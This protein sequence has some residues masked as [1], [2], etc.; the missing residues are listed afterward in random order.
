MSV[1][2]DVLNA[3]S[4]MAQTDMPS[5]HRLVLLFVAN[6]ANATGR[7]WPSIGLLR[8]ETGY[9]RTK[10]ADVLDDLVEHGWL[11][12]DGRVGQGARSVAR[13][14][15]RVGERWPAD[16]RSLLSR[17]TSG[18]RAAKRSCSPGEHVTCS[19]GEHESEVPAA[20]PVNKTC[21]PFAARP[22]NTT[23]SPGE[24][25]LPMNLPVG[26]SHEHP[27]SQNQESGDSSMP[28][29][30]GLGSEAPGSTTRKKPKRGGEEKKPKQVDRYAAAYC[31]AHE[32]TGFP[33][34]ALNEAAKKHLGVVA[35][36]HAKYRDGTPITGDALVQ[37]FYR[38]G[39]A[40]RVDVIDPSRHRGGA[41]PWGFGAW[42]DNGADG[43]ERPL[44]PGAVEPPE[45]EEE[46]EAEP[47]VFR[48]TPEDRAPH[49][50]RLRRM[51]P[52]REAANG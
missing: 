52:P 18:M 44:A 1:F 43:E 26:T 23:R 49:V 39:R 38:R 12:Q 4:S 51:F 28:L 19:P 46:L 24:H 14:E 47:Y 35:A 25:E 2:F 7:S 16:S 10:I 42:L 30:G 40:F 50:A 34:T 41:S 5:A 8:N 48:S 15:V 22:V 21:S 13:F 33:I 20:R 45:P 6:H 9:S 17:A 32:D 29:F 36:T 3:I 11:R 31:K 37:W 27:R